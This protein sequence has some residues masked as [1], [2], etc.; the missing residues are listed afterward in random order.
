M[1]GMSVVGVHE[2]G[3][4]RDVRLR[5]V[6][7]EG[8]EELL[9]AFVQPHPTV[10]QPVGLVEYL[11]VDEQRLDRAQ[12]VGRYEPG[13]R[14]ARAS[15]PDVEG[16]GVR[17]ALGE[18]LVRVLP[19]RACREDH[20]DPVLLLEPGQQILEIGAPQRA[21]DERDDLALLLSRREQRIPLG[22]ER[23]HGIDRPVGGVAT[24]APHR[25]GVGAEVGV[26]RGVAVGSL[27]HA[28]IV[29]PRTINS[30]KPTSQRDQLCRMSSPS[31]L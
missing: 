8:E 24:T 10:V 21:S 30:E 4:V 6:R 12:G 23:C 2:V 28:A 31:F 5:P 9:R 14:R 3:V 27:P 13:D 19:G 7:G 29:I 15:H 20:F 16:V 22:L 26:G 1:L 11:G 18:D 17:G 25:V